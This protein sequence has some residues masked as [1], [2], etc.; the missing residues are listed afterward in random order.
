MRGL[1]W[2]IPILL[3][4]GSEERISVFGLWWCGPC[5]GEW[6]GCLVQGLGGWYGVMYVCSEFGFF[7]DMADPGICVLC[8]ADTCISYVHPV[9][10]P[11]ASDRYLLL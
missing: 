1:G 8:S 4:Q 3:D 11:V 9:V 7:V 2:D 6:V 5:S 10:N